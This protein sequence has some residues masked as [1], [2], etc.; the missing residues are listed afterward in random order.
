M[1]TSEQ[2]KDLTRLFP[3][4]P[5]FTMIDNPQN[6][7]NGYLLRCKAPEQELG[8]DSLLI[9]G[10]DTDGWVHNRLNNDIEKRIDLRKVW[11]KKTGTN[12]Y[13]NVNL[14]VDPSDWERVDQLFFNEFTDEE[15]LQ[16]SQYLNKIILNTYLPSF[17]PFAIVWHL[18]QLKVQEDGSIRERPV[19]AHF[20]YARKTGR[21][22]TAEN[23][24]IRR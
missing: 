8:S 22:T 23:K 3:I 20:M 9:K 14:D 12:L 21:I 19:H 2:L 17:E 18:K 4:N 15:I 1:L 10:P 5:P 24:L 13:V 6:G 7:F 11:W 16:L